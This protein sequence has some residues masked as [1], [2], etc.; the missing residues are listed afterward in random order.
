MANKIVNYSI[1]SFSS[2][3][4]PYWYEYNPDGSTTYHDGATYPYG[5]EH[6]DGTE[7]S[8]I[9]IIR[10]KTD[11]NRTNFAC[12]YFDISQ[13]P[14]ET[15]ISNM[16]VKFRC[17]NCVYVTPRLSLVNQSATYYSSI[18]TDISDPIS[19]D[20]GSES[21]VYSLK[22]TKIATLENK[23]YNEILEYA[24]AN[25]GYRKFALVF[26]LPSEGNS[27]VYVWGAQLEVTYPT[28]KV[29]F[30]SE[31]LLD[32]TSDTVTPSDVLNGSTFHLPNG[33]IST[34][35]CS[36][37]CD[38][39]SDTATAS[40]VASGKTF[41]LASGAQATGNLNVYKLGT[42]S[43]LNT[44][45]N[46][47]IVFSSMLG[48]PQAFVVTTHK[49]LDYT[50]SAT[51]KRVVAVVYN[52]TSTYGFYYVG[53]T[54]GGVQYS[55][56]YSFSYSNNRLTISASSYGQFYSGERYYLTYVY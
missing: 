56:N 41:H 33:I 17:S 24:S 54:G 8:P 53:G 20:A 21:E 38:T 50:S 52:G 49:S 22:P 2:A 45:T 31:I 30:G 28:N 42:I 47:S 5:I 4:N 7:I 12:M 18:F 1:G 9:Y 46:T 32:L 25:P 40:D 43:S 55:T 36:Y 11:S 10:T 23:T 3:A 26:N 14:R 16:E 37:N 51:N 27:K 13:I 44:T 6:V 29:V 19:I 48:E 34:G 15:E 39:S 35:T